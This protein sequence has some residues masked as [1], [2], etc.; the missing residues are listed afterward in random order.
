VQSEALSGRCWR[1]QGL[2]LLG[3]WNQEE[4]GWWIVFMCLEGAAS[5]SA[6]SSSHSMRDTH[7]PSQA[8]P[9]RRKSRVWGAQP[10]SSWI[11]WGGVPFVNFCSLAVTPIPREASASHPASLCLSSL[12]TTLISSQSF[13][14]LHRLPPNQVPFRELY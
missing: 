5:C 2:W 6:C 12:P 3:V 11:P 13:L 1:H 14:L 9:E 8:H 4:G 7:H 10:S